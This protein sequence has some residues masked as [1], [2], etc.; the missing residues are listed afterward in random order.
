MVM[1]MAKTPSVS[2]T[3]LSGLPSRAC[4]GL[5]SDSPTGSMPPW[6]LSLDT[7]EERQLAVL[8][9]ECIQT[10]YQQSLLVL[11]LFCLDEYLTD[12]GQYFELCQVFPNLRLNDESLGRADFG[13]CATAIEQWYS[14]LRRPFVDVI[15][16]WR[17]HTGFVNWVYDVWLLKSRI[18]CCE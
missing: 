18:A 13:T 3:T 1:M 11:E 7:L 2:V 15:V 17:E 12:G 8:F 14:E 16:E 4:W 10:G 5:I 9:P 6:Y